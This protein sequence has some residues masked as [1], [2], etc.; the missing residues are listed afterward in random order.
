MGTEGPS[1]VRRAIRLE[2]DVWR[3]LGR[4]L[5]GRPDVPAGATPFGYVKETA[6]AVWA[7]I[8]L[9]ALEIPLFHLIIPWDVVR[10]VV[11]ALSVWG[12]AWMVGYLASQHVHPHLVGPRTLRVRQWSVVDI[13]VPLDSI[14]GVQHRRR[15]PPTSRGLQIEDAGAETGAIVSVVVAGQTNVDV[16]LHRPTPLVLPR[17]CQLVGRVSLFADDPSA[18]TA[19]LREAVPSADAPS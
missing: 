2:T 3:S 7:F 4:W 17:G 16:L 13:V 11:L 19:R 6:V 18:L 15:S 8:V 10:W 1:A 9:S 14:A 12:L 5:A